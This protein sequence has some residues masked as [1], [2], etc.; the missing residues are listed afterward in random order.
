MGD[1]CSRSWTPSSFKEQSLHRSQYGS[2]IGRTIA[3]AARPGGGGR[4]CRVAA[5][6]PPSCGCTWE[7]AGATLYRSEAADGSYVLG[8]QVIAM[9]RFLAILFSGGLLLLGPLAVSYTHLRAHE[10]R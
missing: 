9:R 1:G 3:C 2:P 6:R 7:G 10:T 4:A 8:G 5:F